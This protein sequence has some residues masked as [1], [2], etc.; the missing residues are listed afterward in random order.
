[1]TPLI[2]YLLAALGAIILIGI[3]LIIQ[4]LRDL[5]GE[6]KE[7]RG[8]LAAHHAA[9]GERIKGLETQVAGIA[10]DVADIDQRLRHVEGIANRLS[11]N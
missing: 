4:A 1:M 7:L 11:P 8:E 10:E 6:V 5:F 9:S 3:K 2:P